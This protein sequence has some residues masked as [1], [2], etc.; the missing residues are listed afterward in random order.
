[1][2]EILTLPQEILASERLAQPDAISES[3]I[4]FSAAMRVVEQF[5]VDAKG[6]PQE[7]Q[8]LFATELGARYTAPLVA[9]DCKRMFDGREYVHVYGKNG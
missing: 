3:D 1:M 2:V 5:G 8:G 9:A 6:A 4:M 7:L